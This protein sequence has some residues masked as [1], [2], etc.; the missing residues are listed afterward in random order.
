MGINWQDP[1]WIV[2]K[3]LYDEKIIPL[4]PMELELKVREYKSNI[5]PIVNKL[6]II[7]SYHPLLSQYTALLKDWIVTKK[8]NPLMRN[9]LYLIGGNIETQRNISWTVQKLKKIFNN[10]EP[11]DVYNELM[12]ILLTL[13]ESYNPS[14]PTSK[15]YNYFMEYF[16]Y[17]LSD[18]IKGIYKKGKTNQY[19][20]S[21]FA[22]NSED[23]VIK[24]ELLSIIEE[25]RD[26]HLLLSKLEMNDLLI[27]LKEVE[28][29]ILYYRYFEDKKFKD[30]ATILNLN[31]Y[32][33]SE[34]HKSALEKIRDQFNLR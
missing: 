11:L 28:R 8:V 32:T 7:K 15:F 30:I 17:K 13:L 19:C 4:T 1:Q 24:N 25:I 34:Y 27:D 5:N 21:I 31:E 9:T 10:W 12:I 2:I 3:N 23:I 6:A 16:K 20:I 29:D 26:N 18:L 22:D 33:I 14:T